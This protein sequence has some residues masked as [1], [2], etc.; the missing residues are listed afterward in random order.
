M[1]RDSAATTRKSAGVAHVDFRC[2]IGVMAVIIVLIAL[3]ALLAVRIRLAL[4][5]A[6]IGL[7][8][9]VQV[10]GSL[11]KMKWF[12]RARA[13][14]TL[15]SFFCDCVFEDPLPRRTRRSLIYRGDCR[16]PPQPGGGVH[17]LLQQKEEG[18]LGIAG[19][20]GRGKGGSWTSAEEKK[21][22]GHRRRRRRGKGK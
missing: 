1:A 19:G 16:R 6:I 3:T 13:K 10:Y 20:G 12:G 4:L 2:A 8:F 7:R 22:D 9:G 11:R 15:R 18:K 5:T 17:R 14:A 21:A